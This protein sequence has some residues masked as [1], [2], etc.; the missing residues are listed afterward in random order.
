MAVAVCLPAS[1]QAA[2]AEQAGA[3][4]FM[5][6]ALAF[7]ARDY[8]DPQAPAYRAL[9]SRRL[10]AAMQLDSADGYINVIEAEVICQCQDSAPSH[11]VTVRPEGSGA[12]ATVEYVWPKGKRPRAIFRLAREGGSW[13]IADIYEIMGQGWLLPRLDASNAQLRRQRGH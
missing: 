2:V 4:D 6:R 13:R 10:D 11:V 8:N 7:A 9:F 3:R 12:L 5:L 1:A